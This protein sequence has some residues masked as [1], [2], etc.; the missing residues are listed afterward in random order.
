VLARRTP[1]NQEPASFARV[2]S[3][4]SDVDVRSGSALFFALT[5]EQSDATVCDLI[6]MNLLALTM[7]N[8][9]NNT[10]LFVALHE[11]RSFRIVQ[12]MV[13]TNKDV[14]MYTRDDG[15]FSLWTALRCEM[16][17]RIITVLIDEN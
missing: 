2:S 1:Q 14:I 3:V 5:Q 4:M 17:P 13:R 16:D 11:R 9:N 6:D 12:H 15:E 7:L 8:T 10:P